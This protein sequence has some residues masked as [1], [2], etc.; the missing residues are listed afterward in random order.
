VKLERAISGGYNVNVL[1]DDYVKSFERADAKY[2]PPK[3]IQV[4]RDFIA[5]DEGRG[6]KQTIS[7]HAIHVITELPARTEA[8]A[9]SDSKDKT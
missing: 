7:A 6:F 4:G 9:E 5:V 1:N 2:V 3:I 8:A